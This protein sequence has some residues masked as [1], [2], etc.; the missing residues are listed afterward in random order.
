M[1][2]QRGRGRT[3]PDPTC[4]PPGPGSTSV[5]R[6]TSLRSIN[7]S[8]MAPT[9][10]SPAATNP[11]RANMR[12]WTPLTIRTSRT[13]AMPGGGNRS[14]LK[15]REESS[16]IHTAMAIVRI[17]VIAAKTRIVE[18]IWETASTGSSSTFSST[19]VKAL[20]KAHMTTTPTAATINTR[21]RAFFVQQDPPAEFRLRWLLSLPAPHSPR[22][23]E[24]DMRLIWMLMPA[25]V[26]DESAHFLTSGGSNLSNLSRRAA[27]LSSTITRSRFSC[28]TNSASTV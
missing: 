18:T 26:S 6:L 21:N 23:S 28:L 16:Q 12:A 1:T 24:M 22:Y 5:I 17:A 3:H 9:A 13:R 11:T 2:G 20:S 10:Q 25:Q 19:P 7:G 15:M 4:Q 27:A 8:T 14:A